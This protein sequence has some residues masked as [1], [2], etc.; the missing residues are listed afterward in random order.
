VEAQAADLAFKLDGTLL[1]VFELDGALF[2]VRDEHL[3]CD[4][5]SDKA[6]QPVVGRVEVGLQV[7]E[8]LLQFGVKRRGRHPLDDAAEQ[9]HQGTGLRLLGDGEGKPLAYLIILGEV[10]LQELL[11]SGGLI[12]QEGGAYRLVCDGAVSGQ[13]GTELR[14]ILCV[15]SER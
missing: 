11:V 9:V 7:Q 2:Q 14:L 5:F 13:Q 6:E 15:V 4:F 8:P 1:K 3:T 12:A 10:E